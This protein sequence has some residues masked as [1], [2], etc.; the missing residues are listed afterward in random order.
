[1]KEG[2]SRADG[3]AKR[4]ARA[5]AASSCR[6]DH[7]VARPF[8]APPPASPS[9]APGVALRARQSSPPRPPSFPP[10][11]P[12]AI[13]PPARGKA[14]RIL[15]VAAGAAL[16]VLTAGWYFF[17]GPGAAAIRDAFAGKPNTPEP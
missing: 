10:P 13:A 14:W 16:L 8:A 2:V 17:R 12:P 1:M 7:P 5:S 11:G 4:P 3:K 6:R 15:A 9:H